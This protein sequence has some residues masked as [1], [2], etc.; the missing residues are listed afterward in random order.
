MSNEIQNNELFPFIE[1]N[2]DGRIIMVSP[3]YSMPLERYVSLFCPITEDAD[4]EV[5]QPLA[6]PEPENKTL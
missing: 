5:V 6:L 2:E 1:E 3:T 4:F